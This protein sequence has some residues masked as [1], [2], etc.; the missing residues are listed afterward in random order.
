MKLPTCVFVSDVAVKYGA[1]MLLKL[2]FV[3]DVVIDEVGRS[4]TMRN[5]KHG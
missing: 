1:A 4:I 3:A 2:V 5:V